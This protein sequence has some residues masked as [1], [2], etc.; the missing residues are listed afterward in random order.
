MKTVKSN[1][2]EGFVSTFVN[3]G[4]ISA[5][6]V[7]DAAIVCLFYQLLSPRD[8]ATQSC[9]YVPLNHL[10]S[11]FAM[12]PQTTENTKFYEM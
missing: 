10:R 2:P 4:W 9:L 3:A 7:L 5:Q 11:L 8:P 6:R 1:D 12:Y